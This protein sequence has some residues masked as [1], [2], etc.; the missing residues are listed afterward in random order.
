M[1]EYSKEEYER[2]DE[3]RVKADSSSRKAVPPA[4]GGLEVW[5]KICRR[6]VRSAKKRE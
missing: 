5:R 3:L 2:A 1:A 6:C 4:D